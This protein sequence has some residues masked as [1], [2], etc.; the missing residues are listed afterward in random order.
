MRG[1]YRTLVLGGHEPPPCS[2]TNKQTNGLNGTLEDYL[3]FP[4]TSNVFINEFWSKRVQFFFTIFV[5]FNHIDDLDFIILTSFITSFRPRKNIFTFCN[6]DEYKKNQALHVFSLDLLLTKYALQ[7]PKV[8]DYEINVEFII[9]NVQL[10]IHFMT[11]QCLKIVQK[12]AFNVASEACYV[13]I[14]RRQKSIKKAKNSQFWRVF[15]NLNLA[16]KLCYHLPDIFLEMPKFKNSNATF[17][18]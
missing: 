1:V 16:V 9:G 11:A 13:Y 4:L 8:M 5:V 2:K 6:A 10:L 14:L 12:V 3:I 15:E 17:L 18:K 7:V